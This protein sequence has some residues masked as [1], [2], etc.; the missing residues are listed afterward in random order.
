[1][2]KSASTSLILLGILA[3]VAGIVAIARPGVTVLAL[4]V[5]FSVF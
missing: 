3:V 1:M 4:V 5:M 2:I